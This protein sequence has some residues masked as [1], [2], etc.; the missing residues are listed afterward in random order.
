M[1]NQKRVFYP[2]DI[3]QETGLG[4]NL[5]YR[6]LRAGE[7]C[8]IKAGDRYLISRAN[9]EKWLNGNYVKKVAPDEKEKTA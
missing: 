2:E 4:L 8:H 9:F 6:L 3:A 1:D 7:I 5:I